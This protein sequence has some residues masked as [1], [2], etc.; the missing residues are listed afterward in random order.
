[1]MTLIAMALPEWRISSIACALASLPALIIIVFVFPESPTWLHN[2]GKLEQMKKSEQHIAKVA[3]I[4]YVPVNH[5]KIEH[6]KV[7]L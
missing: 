5:Q 7:R 6:S 1:M 4:P 3:G 2:K